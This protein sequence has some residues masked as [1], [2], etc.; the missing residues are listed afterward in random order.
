MP[1]WLILLCIMDSGLGLF[2]MSCTA[3]VNSVSNLC[4]KCHEIICDISSIIAIE[5]SCTAIEMS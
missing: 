5:M 3:I 1:L 2:E 4:F